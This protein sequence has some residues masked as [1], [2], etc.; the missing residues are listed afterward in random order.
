MRQRPQVQALLRGVLARGPQRAAGGEAGMARR[1]IIVESPAKARTIHKFLGK[2]YEVKAS[3]GHV[4]DLPKNPKKKGEPDWIGID[5]D[6]DF[7]PHYA[8]L[9]DKKKIVDDILQAAHRADAVLLA[10]DPDREGEAICWHLE[11]LLKADKVQKPIGRILFH[12]ITARA[13]QA[14]VAAPRPIC[15]APRPPIPTRPAPG[16]P[17]RRLAQ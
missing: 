6:Q 11:Q 5:E 3:M 1:L 2:G 4:R 8:V 12:E 10:A 9:R 14:G 13:V 7:R 17:T 15:A 16:H